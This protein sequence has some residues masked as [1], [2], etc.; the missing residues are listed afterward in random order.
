MDAIID[1]GALLAGVDLRCG[2]FAMCY[3]ADS[4][5]SGPAQ[6]RVAPDT[7]LQP[8]PPTHV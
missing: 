1:C 3:R 5:C 8:A 6:T 4:C 7:A 2:T